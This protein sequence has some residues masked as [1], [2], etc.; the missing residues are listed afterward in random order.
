MFRLIVV[1]SGSVG[2]CVAQTVALRGLADEVVL[3]DKRPARAAA[4]AAD[5]MCA[6]PRMG[7]TCAVR[8]GGYADASS[9]DAVVLCAAAPARL[10][11]TRNDM[12]ARNAGILLDVASQVEGAGFAGLYVVVSNPVD[13]LAHHLVREGGVPASRVVGTG[14]LLDGLRVE[15]R[16]RSR[17]GAGSDVRALALGEH[18]EGLVVDWSRTL[19]DGR[20]VPEA[21]REAIRREA[22]DAAYDIMKGKGSTSYGIALAVSEIVSAL[23]ARDGRAL[24]LSVPAG[25]AYGIE[26][27]TLALPVAFGEGGAPAV[28]PLELDGGTGESLRSVAAGMRE[29]YDSMTREGA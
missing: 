29:A 1:G 18:G 27:V 9:A 14:T 3:V 15:D 5:L 2:S 13:L 16:M 6:L 23:R 17:Y 20:P 8:A 28:V 4:E 12:F 25:G 22:I 26:G 10:G 19:V 24:P 11:Q 21:D 7:A